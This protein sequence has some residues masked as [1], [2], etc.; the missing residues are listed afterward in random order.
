MF[1]EGRLRQNQAC[2]DSDVIAYSAAVTACAKTVLCQA[3][4]T[5]TVVHNDI[6]A[7]Q[8]TPTSRLSST[9]RHHGPTV[10]GDITAQ[11]HTAT[12]RPSS[13]RRQHG[14]AAHRTYSKVRSPAVLL[15]T[16]MKKHR[17]YFKQLDLAKHSVCTVPKTDRRPNCTMAP[18]LYHDACTVGANITALMQYPE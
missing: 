13:T 10:H 9:R 2:G 3:Q 5:K 17:T 18:A 16:K 12:S 14:S 1:R 7:Q 4:H 6:T 15:C 8:H 11:Q